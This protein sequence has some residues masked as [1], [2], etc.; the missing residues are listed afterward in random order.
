MFLLIIF[1]FDVDVSVVR[2]ILLECGGFFGVGVNIV[3][4]EVEI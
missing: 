2:L 4:D 1:L 3:S